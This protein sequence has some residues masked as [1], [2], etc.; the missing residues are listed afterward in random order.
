MSTEESL[1]ERVRELWEKNHIQKTMLEI[2]NGEGYSITPRQLQR[3]RAK[4]GLMLRASN[5]TG[6]DA[7][8]EGEEEQMPKPAEPQIPLEVQIERQARQAKLWVESAERLKNKTRRRR[9]R[10]WCGLPADVGLPP[11]FPSELTLEESRAVLHLNKA[12]HSELK[13]IFQGIC[14]THGVQRKSGNAP[15][16]WQFAKGELV[17]ASPKLQAVFHSPQA[18]SFDPN[19]EPMALDVICMDV[20]KRIRQ[21]GQAMSIME[22][23][24]VL[25]LTPDETREIRNIFQNILIETY[26]TKKLDVGK[27]HWNEL[28]HKWL[29]RSPRLQREFQAQDGPNQQAQKFRALEAIALDVSKRKRDTDA[30]RDTN[31]SNKRKAS[32]KKPG[33][34]PTPSKKARTTKEKASPSKAR[35]SQAKELPTRDPDWRSANGR[36]PWMPS[37]PPPDSQ[38]NQPNA[39]SQPQHLEPSIDHHHLHE[40]AAAAQID[41]DLLRAANLPPHNNNIG[42]AAP[43]PPLMSSQPNLQA[44]SPQP[45]TAPQGYTSQANDVSSSPNTAATSTPIYI[46]PTP[47]SLERFPSLP[48]VWLDRLA[49]PMTF[50]KLV[51]V[52]EKKI[53]T[54]ALVSKIEG[55]VGEE[56][57]ERW[58]IDDDDEVE[59]FVQFVRGEGGKVVFAVE[60]G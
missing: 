58:S 39:A 25:G 2:L 30:G 23:K 26:F 14:E 41:P 36:P 10:G 16:M 9:M 13:K 49:S 20:T 33:E 21:A 15:G 48:K 6:K 57:G 19:K 42:W 22:S 44:P 59:G 18:A 12:E 60:V 24:N 38:S 40:L 28:K 17:N 11:R 32:N 54:Q 56:S 50:R 52:V 53:G 51:D 45:V 8:D 43:P 4:H 3:L 7:A 47:S 37:T 31:A 1:L 35:T 55:V 27:E 34:T 5:E 29:E 46:R